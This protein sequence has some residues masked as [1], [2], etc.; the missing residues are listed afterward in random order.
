MSKKWGE[1]FLKSGLPLEH[2]TA[3]ALR[4]LGWDIET[5]LEYSRQN[6]D[7]NETWFELDLFATSPGENKDT[8]LGFLIECK[9]HDA[10]RFWVLLPSEEGGWLFDDAVLNCGP[11]QTLCDPRK[12]SFL[13]LAP[14]STWGVVVSE[15]G[16]KQE[17]A[18]HTAIQQLTNAFVPYL[19]GRL[20]QCDLFLNPRATA[21][22]PMI[23]TNASL[24][25]LRPEIR[26]LEVIRN[27]SSPAEVADEVS[28]TWCRH[29]IPMALLDA[30]QETIRLSLVQYADSIARVPA[31]EKR[32]M[33]FGSRPHWIAV[34]NIKAL[35]DAAM[36]IV[37]QFM[38]LQIA[39]VRT[40]A[41]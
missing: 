17:N 12:E 20:W 7:G 33:V 1:S 13:G 24:Y 36:S 27:A 18:I 28:W 40:V 32:L 3:M 21:V 35:A 23:V 5:N 37:S 8:E 39:D 38:E 29:A 41:K 19:S 15:D 4:S 30:N 6:K 31:A 26:D 34:V 10:S 16:T 22:V 25:R 2:L 9:Y 11:V 14:T